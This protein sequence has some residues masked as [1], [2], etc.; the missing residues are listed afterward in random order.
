MVAIEKFKNFVLDRQFNTSE[1]DIILST[2]HSAKGMEWDQ[3]QLCE[4]SS[5]SLCRFNKK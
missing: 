4:E 3:V 2:V 1:A 5:R